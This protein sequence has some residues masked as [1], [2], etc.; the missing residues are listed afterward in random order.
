MSLGFV[1]A[2][3]NAAL[4]TVSATCAFFGWRAIRRKDVERHKRLM[5]GAFVASG[6]FLA[7]YL[8]RIVMFG[9]TKFTGEGTIRIVYF[10]VL[11][12]HVLLAMVSAPLVV[13]TLVLG[14]KK[15]VAVHRR[16][17]R[18]TLPIWVYV[19]ITGVVVYWFLR[20]AY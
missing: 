20:D 19:S 9:D 6:L 16:L 5:L 8:T 4:N 11:I 12:S 2:S 15:K 18:I 10:G 13:T 14:L 1:L 17:A 7:S 3:L